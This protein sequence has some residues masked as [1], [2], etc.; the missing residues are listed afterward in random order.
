MGTGYQEI[1]RAATGCAAEDVE[2]VEAIMRDVVLHS[3]LDWLTRDELE[4]A[5]RKAHLVFLHLNDQAASDH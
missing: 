3:T 5:A 2:Q 1:I 4:T